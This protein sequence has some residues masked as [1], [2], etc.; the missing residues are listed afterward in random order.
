V[1]QVM[2]VMCVWRDFKME[3]LV[4]NPGFTTRVKL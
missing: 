3:D 4:E 2:E 1:Q